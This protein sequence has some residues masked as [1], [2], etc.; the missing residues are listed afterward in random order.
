M[1]QPA[2]NSGKPQPTGK[3]WAIA[4]LL[5]VLVVPIGFLFWLRQADPETVRTLTNQGIA[6]MERFEYTEAGKKFEDA[7]LLDP[8]NTDL[9]INLGIALLNQASDGSLAR[10][11]QTFEE[12]LRKDPN[13][14]NAH[15]CLGIIAYYQN[16]AED[17]ARSFQAVLEKDP[18]D[19]FSWY[20]LGKFHPE[21][22]DSE[23]S[24]KCLRRALELDPYLN[25]ARYAIALHPQLDNPEERKRL[26]EEHERLKQADWER[27]QEISYPNMGPLASILG[28][29][30]PPRDGS[31]APVPNFRRGTPGPADLGPGRSW[32]AEDSWP[33]G[34]ATTLF[35]DVRDRFGGCL[36]LGDFKRDGYPDAF[37]G[38][39]ILE[40]GKI[41][42]LY[43][44]QH[45]PGDWTVVPLPLPAGWFSWGAVAADFDND[46]HT[47][48]AVCGPKGIRF[49]RNKGDGEFELKPLVGKTGSFEVPIFGLRAIDLDQD[50]D[51]DLVFVILGENEAEGSLAFKGQPKGARSGQVCAWMNQGVAPATAPNEPMAALSW[52]WES[53]PDNLFPRVAGAF[54]L[55][56]GDPDNDGDLD[57]IVFSAG[58]RASMIF[59]DRLLRFSGPAE[60]GPQDSHPTSGLVA[61]IDLDG[62]CDLVLNGPDTP[63]VLLL[64]RPNG[65]PGKPAIELGATSGPAMRQVVAGDVDRNGST[66]LIGV[67]TGGRVAIVRNHAAKLSFD[68]NSL[69]GSTQSAPNPI[70]AIGYADGDGDGKSDLWTW[71]PRTGLEYRINLGNGNQGLKVLLAG[72]RDKADSL[73]TNNDAIGAKMESLEGSIRSTVELATLASGPAQSMVPV[74]LGVGRSLEASVLRIRWP[75]R[76]VQAEKNLSTAVVHKIPETNRKATSCPVLFIETEKGMTMVTDLLGAGAIGEQ[77][78]GG[79]IRPPRPSESLWI[80]PPAPLAKNRPLRLSLAEPMDEVMYL[81]RVLV[82]A[83]D[84]PAG[85]TASVDERFVFSGPQPSGDLLIFPEYRYPQWGKKLDGRECT[86]ELSRRDRHYPRDYPLRS[87]LGFAGDHGWEMA[88]D[89]LDAKPQDR[90]YLVLDAW[91]DYPYPESLYAAAQAGVVAKPLTLEVPDGKGGW[92]AALELGLPAG[93]PKQLTIEVTS[94]GAKLQGPMRIVTNLRVAMDAIRLARLAR[95]GEKALVHELKLRS[96]HLDSPGVFK[97]EAVGDGLIRYRR[98]AIETPG[99]VSE[100]KG[101]FTRRGSVYSLLVERDDLLMIGGPGDEV[102]MEFAEPPRLATGSTRGYFLKV[103]GYCKDTAP[104]TKSAGEVKPWPYAAMAAFPG[105]A[106]HPREREMAEWTTRKPDQPPEARSPRAASVKNKNQ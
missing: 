66:D 81:D 69:S 77:G 36:C 29:F 86:A 74:D 60:I 54:H 48:L 103:D 59:N 28:A 45:T 44:A 64:C 30:K 25:A 87:W 73:R 12:V 93:L 34:P 100:W 53:A 89:K 96:A 16:R 78:A 33:E 38:G 101:N 4:G 98:D 24:M 76:V 55:M 37:L 1:S 5:V 19:A 102:T 46:G 84:L 99:Q 43:L 97:E 105:S 91:T 65:T 72:R 41:R 106:A 71:Y 40:Q 14:L 20:Y 47:D 11:I 21:G 3:Y 83:V 67:M 52:A 23:A 56:L 68:Q 32:A 18:N 17:A 63:P 39:A 62:Y 6:E 94:L 31:A 35:K 13:N 92:T 7:L 10:S 8:N 95:P 104:F 26:L 22:S 42:D 15:F 61:D 57:L 82:Q 58:K 85:W 2:Q 79:S 80:E 51:L 90:F 88:F 70:A 49:L 27:T 50:G 75:D 9:K